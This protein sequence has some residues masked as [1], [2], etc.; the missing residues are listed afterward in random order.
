MKSTVSVVIPTIGR[1]SVVRAV[2]SAAGQTYPVSIVVV[3][4]IP[5]AEGVVRQQLREFDTTIITTTGR[6]GGSAARN[7]GAAVGDSDYIAFLDDDDWWEPTK[8]EEQLA[9][10][11]GDEAPA[12]ALSATAMFFHRKTSTEVIPSIPYSGDVEDAASYLVTRSG[13]KFGNRAMQTSGLLVSRKL[14][15]RVLWDEPL[16]KHQDWDYIARASRIESLE[17]GWVPEPLV[18]VQQDSHGSISKKSN[19]E[20]SLRWLRTHEKHMS[21]RARADFVCSHVLRASLAQRS[22]KGIATAA[23]EIVKAG[24]P[25]GAALIVGLSGIR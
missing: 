20:A 13:I 7:L 12:M 1:E 15:E 2:R 5:D 19:Y 4:D 25:H 23:R 18:H 9:S 22:P 21:R 11:G 17:L 14:H 6:V 16:P 24:V 8:I 3:V 10:V